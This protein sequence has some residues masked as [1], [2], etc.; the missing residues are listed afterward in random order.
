M[1]RTRAADGMDD[2]CLAAGFDVCAFCA[3]ENAFSR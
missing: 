1:G 2:G 3:M